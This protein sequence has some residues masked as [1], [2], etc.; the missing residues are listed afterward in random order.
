MSNKTRPVIMVLIG[1]YLAYTGVTLTM[2]AWQ[3]RPEHYVFMICCGVVFAV[4]GVFAIVM[5]VR[6]M[7]HQTK[8]PD[9]EQIEE[10]KESGE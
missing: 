5:S 2:D 3:G 8:N 6:N 4:F 10:D 1:A 7:I 9:S